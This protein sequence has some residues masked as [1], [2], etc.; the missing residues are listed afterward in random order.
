MTSHLTR[1]LIAAATLISGILAGGNVN[2]AVDGPA[3]Q[4]LGVLAWAEYSRYADLS[5]G[6]RILFPTEA[7]GAMILS[8]AAVLSFRR[9]G[10]EP[11]SVAFP[12]YAAALCAIGG[13]LIT[14]KAAP[15]M[16]S[17]GHLGSDTVALQ[18]AQDGFGFWDRIRGVFQVLA[19][20]ANFWSLVALPKPARRI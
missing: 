1:N 18:R 7:F 16:L 4:H 13:L 2:G 10:K 6:A 14:I 9:D 5:L 17:I 19:Y 15:I 12:I 11:R 8:V 20:L 3:W